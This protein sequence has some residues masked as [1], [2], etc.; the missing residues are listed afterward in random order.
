MARRI[1]LP[2][3]SWEK[4]MSISA[5]VRRTIEDDWLIVKPVR[6]GAVPSGLGTPDR[7]VLASDDEGP[8]LRLD[9]YLADTE[10]AAFEAVTTWHDWIVVGIGS[11]IYLVALGD[12]TA[13]VVD[14]E[15]GFCQLFPMAD[16][17]LATSAEC[18]VRIER[19]GSIGWRSPRVGLDG[20]I[21][22]EV[23]STVIQG[24][25]D[26]DP[27]GGWKEFKLDVASGKRVG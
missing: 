20:V 19:D 23:G 7:Y 8:R 3:H 18:I 9:I 25:G 1:R 22:R 21:V 16:Y 27:P 26:W 5:E 12:L 4:V 17:L 6:L 11:R 10:S 24:E 2:K 14:L 13:T 15:A